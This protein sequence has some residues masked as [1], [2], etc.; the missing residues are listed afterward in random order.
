MSSRDLTWNSHKGCDVGYCWNDL[1][2]PVFLE[3]QK[4]LVTEFGI[5]QRLEGCV[6]SNSYNC[7]FAL[8][9]NQVQLITFNKQT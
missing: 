3:G 2:E 4:P 9:C 8:N 1:D 7:I 5:H 6:N